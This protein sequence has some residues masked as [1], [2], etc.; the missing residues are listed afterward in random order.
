[1]HFCVCSLTSSLVPKKEVPW[2]IT[3]AP[4][5]LSMWLTLSISLSQVKRLELRG[6]KQCLPLHSG[7]SWNRNPRSSDR[8]PILTTVYRA[9]EASA[10]GPRAGLVDSKGAVWGLCV[11]D[12]GLCVGSV[13]ICGMNEFY[14]LTARP[15]RVKVRSRYFLQLKQSTC[16]NRELE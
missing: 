2:H 3:D 14:L 13:K 12:L 6:V 7:Q 8:Q 9:K 11:L 16:H 1:M 10:K 15:L 4:Y 5:T